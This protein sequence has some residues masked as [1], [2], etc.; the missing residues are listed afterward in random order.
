MVSFSYLAT[1]R[2]VTQTRPR[3]Q[4]FI[5]TTNLGKP[6]PLT[7][8][9]LRPAGIGFAVFDFAYVAES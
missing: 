5:L 7:F 8:L 1:K 9:K 6:C 2:K 4:N 3:W